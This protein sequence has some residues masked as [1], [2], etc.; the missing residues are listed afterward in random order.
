[1]GCHSR[2][3]F[4]VGELA[5]VGL[6]FSAKN[7]DVRCTE[8][9]GQIN[10]S[11]RISQFLCPFG[12]I[13]EVQIGRAA[14]TSNL[15]PAFANFPLRFLDSVRPKTRVRWQMEIP[16]KPAQFY[17]TEPVLPGKIQ[18]FRPIPSGTAQV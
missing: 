16:H 15:Q 18:D 2:L 5:S 1:A 7:T 12:L 4:L 13:T 9:R 14:D 6:F 11:T 17:D 10:E 3:R 8:A